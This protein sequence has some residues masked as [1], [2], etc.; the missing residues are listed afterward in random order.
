M[1]GYRTDLQ[2][3]HGLASN[4]VNATCFSN[5]TTKNVWKHFV[6]TIDSNIMKFYE[7]VILLDSESTNFSLNYGTSPLC[8]GSTQQNYDGYFNGVIDDI[9]IWNRILTQDE[10]NKLYLDCSDFN[11]ND[12]TSY[13]VS[14]KNF[15]SLLPEIYFKRTDSLITTIR[16]DSI[17]NRYSKFIY[18]PNYF[19]DT[20]SVEDTLNIMINVSV[21][22]TP[23][24]NEVKLYP[25]PTKDNL[26]IDCSNYL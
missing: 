20:I 5:T 26:W 11:Y 12:T 18:N 9:G 21:N 2:K 25:N 24:I 1:I 17:I 16:C 14:N 23:D 4:G 19:T 13:Y 8:F 22:P 3:F 7:N 6:P 10:I 15:E